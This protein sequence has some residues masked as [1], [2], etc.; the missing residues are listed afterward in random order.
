VERLS[1]CRVLLGWNNSGV[2]RLRYP[3]MLSL[4]E[5]CGRSWPYTV[6][7][8]DSNLQ[9]DYPASWL[10]KSGLYVV[11]GHDLK[12]VL[13]YKL[14]PEV[15]RS[16]WT[17]IND[18]RSWEVREGA[19]KRNA[20]TRFQSTQPWLAWSKAVDFT[21]RKQITSV[22]VDVRFD[23]SS[24]ANTVGLFAP[25]QDESNWT[26]LVWSRGSA[27]AGIQEESHGG[28]L[29]LQ[30]HSSHVSRSAFQRVE[31]RSG[32]WYRMTLSRSGPDVRWRVIERDTGAA[33][34]SGVALKARWEGS[35]VAVGSREGAC[36]FDNLKVTYGSN[37]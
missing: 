7:L 21:A 33:I 14:D 26:A 3:L 2:M 34:A 10:A 23:E 37:Q 28:P 1:A 29:A 20:G 11:Y 15:L 12:R 19:L 5:D 8:D 18:R 4:T 16:P 17:I 31:A 9:L 30:G 32:V 24:T 25:Y 22:E 35:F 13:L 27:S 6:T 36:S